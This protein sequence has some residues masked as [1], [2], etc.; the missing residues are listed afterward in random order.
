MYR[1]LADMI[2]VLHIAYVSYVVFGQLAI[3]IG[4][5]LGWRW[6]RN[7]WFRMTHLAAILIV[8]LEVFASIQCPLTVWER[9]LRG[10]ANDERSFMA[11]LHG[12]LTFDA[13]QEYLFNAICIVLGVLIV[14]TIVL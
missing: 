10:E 2:L 4:W 6:I 13:D 12:S 3:L 9:E 14:T 7:P 1:V 5:P 8:V 11:R